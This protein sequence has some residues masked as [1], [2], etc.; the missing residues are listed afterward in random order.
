[1]NLTNYN[2]DNRLST[3]ALAGLYFSHAHILSGDV[4]RTVDYFAQAFGGRVAFELPDAAS[5]PSDRL[6]RT[7]L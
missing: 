5:A 3:A 6:Y 7:N 2:N 1:M 4:T